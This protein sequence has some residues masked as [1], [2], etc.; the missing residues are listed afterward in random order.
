MTEQPNTHRVL[1]A[2]GGVAGL[3]A[4]IALHHLAGDRVDVTLVAPSDE[5]TIKAL[6]VNEPF[7]R[8]S[9]AAYDVETVCADHGATYRRDAVHAVLP[10]RCSVVLRSGMDL[11]Y[12]SLVVAVGGRPH[13][14]FPEALTFR[15]AY[16]ADL[17]MHLLGAVDRGHVSDIAFVVPSGPSWPLPL[18]ELALM[19]AER[20]AASDLA[21]RLTILT[22]EPEP[23]AVFGHNAS[24]VVS[25]LL[26]DHA[27]VVHTDVHVHS[28]DGR[29]VAAV[30][31]EVFVDA[32]AI[33]AVPELRGPAIGG[34]PHDPHGFLP[35][36]VDGRV[37]DVEGVFG[38]GDG[39]T[40]PVKQGGVAAQQADIAAHAIA[41]RAG[42]PLQR[43]TFRPVLR[44]ELL[45][46]SGARY[47]REAV[48]GGGG[49]QASEQSGHA[50]WWPPA[51]VAAP[52]LAPYLERLD[53]GL[54]GPQ[55]DPVARRLHGTGDP[56][57]GLEVLG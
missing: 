1:V 13:V 35:V 24:A 31:G 8:P 55:P 23:L 10:Q 7:G 34:L 52:Y 57:R 43:R 45:T 3:E 20:G 30:P 4:V 47:L 38:A 29:T 9:S 41:I 48:A 46:G 56:A 50:L 25:R 51:K 33:V 5:F 27:V 12:D 21:L 28:V 44:G 42:A 53:A 36:Q 37:P 18:Y 11:G 16:D 32:D 40:F 2:G 39:T 17:M 49:E 15:G 54:R 22:P 14:T 26:A 6:S 19:T